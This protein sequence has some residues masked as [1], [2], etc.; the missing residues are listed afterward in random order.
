MIMEG[1]LNDREQRVVIDGQ[2][3]EW[4]PVAAVVPKSSIID[5]FLFLDYIIDIAVVISSDIKIFANNTFI[6]R[7]ADNNSTTKLNSITC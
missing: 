3:S 1:F 6:H 4:L 2:L 7:L 5:P